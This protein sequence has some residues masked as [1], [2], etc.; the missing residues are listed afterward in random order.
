M[1][2]RRCAAFTMNEVVF[3]FLFVWK[4]YAQTPQPNDYHQHLLSP[5]VASITGTAKPFEARLL[6]EQMDAAGT[7]RGV[8]LSMAYQFGNPNRP[9]V[10]DE[11]GKGQG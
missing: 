6:I 8:I 5:A 11:Y 7:R 10:A 1:S 2:G 3:A 4:A 9:L